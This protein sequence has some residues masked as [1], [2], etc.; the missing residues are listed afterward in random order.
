MKTFKKLRE[1]LSERSLISEQL[2]PE[3]Q[4]LFDKH[5]K[6]A[7]EHN[8]QK[9]RYSSYYSSAHPQTMAHRDMEQAHHAIAHHIDI[10]HGGGRGGVHPDLHKHSQHHVDTV[11]K[12]KDYLDHEH[13]SNAHDL[14]KSLSNMKKD[15]DN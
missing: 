12:H 10:Y 5:K 9:R 3:H 8:D 11:K 7:E 1:E 4:K 13:I 14:H 15:G 6:A 2:K